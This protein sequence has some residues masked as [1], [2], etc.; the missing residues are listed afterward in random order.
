MLLKHQRI[1]FGNKLSKE[2]WKQKIRE[3]HIPKCHHSNEEEWL[4]G[5]CAQEAINTNTELKEAL[6]K[7]IG[8]RESWEK[9][10]DTLIDKIYY[11]K[12]KHHKST[13]ETNMLIRM[14]ERNRRDLLVVFNVLEKSIDAI[15][16][17]WKKLK[18]SDKHDEHHG[19]NNCYNVVEHDNLNQISIAVD[20]C[21]YT[22]RN[23]HDRIHYNF[24][25][26][27]TGHDEYGNPSYRDPYI[28]HSLDI[29]YQ[30]YEM[31]ERSFW[32]E[33]ERQVRQSQEKLMVAENN[34]L[35]NDELPF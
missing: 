4:C 25:D 31:R 12:E 13:L 33:Q 29:E 11:M 7:E 1:E 15:S 34:S 26:N 19:L 8:E 9:E 32:M 5:D 2:E 27:V 24:V 10:R 23:C 21:L 28:S 18:I 20:D 17:V 6:E 35:T 22:L 30:E 3:Y 16:E 14:C